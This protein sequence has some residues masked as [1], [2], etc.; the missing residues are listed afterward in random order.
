M[1]PIW[2]GRKYKLEKSENFEEFLVAL[3]NKE[4]LRENVGLFY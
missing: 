4:N 2:L 1:T 3:G